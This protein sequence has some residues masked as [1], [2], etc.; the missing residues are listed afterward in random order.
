MKEGFIIQVYWPA[1]DDN[2]YVF[3]FKSENTTAK[4]TAKWIEKKNYT[5][6]I[7]AI[8]NIKFK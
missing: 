8:F 3:Y 5:C 7:I 2:Q 1:V 6:K 4:S